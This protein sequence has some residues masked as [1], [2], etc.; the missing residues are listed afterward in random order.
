MKNILITGATGFL[1]WQLI[2][3]CLRKNHKP[4]A[5]GHS[6]LRVVKT[7]KSFPDLPIYCLD[8]SSHKDQIKKIIDKHIW[9]IKKNAVNSQLTYQERRRD[10]PFDVLATL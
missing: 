5:I 1:G 8:I 2:K 4:V 6:E 3:E 7:A 9:E 10:R